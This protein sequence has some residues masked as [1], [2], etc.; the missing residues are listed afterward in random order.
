MTNES[1]IEG[2][3]LKYGDH[4]DTD[5]IIPQMFWDFRKSRFNTAEAHL[6]VLELVWNMTQVISFAGQILSYL[7]IYYKI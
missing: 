6:L 5:V 3:V 4:I 7:L 2:K 1:I